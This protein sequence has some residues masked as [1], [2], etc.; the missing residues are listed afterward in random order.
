MGI[1][2]PEMD[3]YE[4]ARRLR[5]DP[6]FKDTVMIAVSVMDGTPTSVMDGTPT[7]S[8]RARPASTSI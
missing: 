7:S 4:V 2:L 6:R 5:Q 3:G 8:Y 1:G